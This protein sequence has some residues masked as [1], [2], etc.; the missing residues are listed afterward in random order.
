ML[1]NF[2]IRFYFLYLFVTNLGH[3]FFLYLSVIRG[4]EEIENEGIDKRR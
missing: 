1:T 4:F 2:D 3:F